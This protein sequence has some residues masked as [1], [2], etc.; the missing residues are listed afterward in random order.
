MLTKERILGQRAVEQG[1]PRDLLCR[2]VAVSGFMVTGLVSVLSLDS[3][4]DTGPSWWCS[5]CSAKMDASEKDSGRWSD[6]CSLLL[7][8]SWLFS[9]V[10]LTGISCYNSRKW[11]LW[12]LARVGYFSEFAFLTVL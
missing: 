10:F 4:S 1:N 2:M 7:N 11:L 8:F 6:M 3:R 9:S 5:H 12:C